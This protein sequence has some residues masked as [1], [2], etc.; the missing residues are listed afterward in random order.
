MTIIEKEILAS[1]LSRSDINFKQAL[2][3]LKLR[4]RGFQV[5]VNLYSGDM[6]PQFQVLI[7][8]DLIKLLQLKYDPKVEKIISED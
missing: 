1:T 7:G 4:N 6:S 8:M 3:E 5:C 2:I